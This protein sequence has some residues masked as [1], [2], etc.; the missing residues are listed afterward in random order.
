MNLIERIY[1]E[2]VKATSSQREDERFTLLFQRGCLPEYIMDEDENKAEKAVSIIANVMCKPYQLCNETQ[3]MMLPVLYRYALDNRIPS[4]WNKNRLVHTKNTMTSVKSNPYY[5]LL[6]DAKQSMEQAKK[7]LTDGSVIYPVRLHPKNWKDNLK[8]GFSNIDLLGS[9]EMYMADYIKMMEKRERLIRSV[10][11]YSAETV[12]SETV[13]G[14]KDIL[15]VLPESHYYLGIFR[16]IDKVSENTWEKLFCLLKCGTDEEKLEIRENIIQ[17]E[18]ELCRFESLSHEYFESVQEKK[19]YLKEFKNEIM[20]LQGDIRKQ[21][22]N[23]ELSMYK[24]INEGDSLSGILPHNIDET[25]EEI[26][27]SGT[28]GELLEATTLSFEDKNIMM[29]LNCLFSG[30]V[31]REMDEQLLNGHLQIIIGGLAKRV[32]IEREWFRKEVIQ[33]DKFKSIAEVDFNT[34]PSAFV[35]M[36]DITIKFIFDAVSII[37]VKKFIR[38]IR[39]N[40]SFLCFGEIYQDRTANYDL[41]GYTLMCKYD[42]PVLLGYYQEQVN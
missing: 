9:S 24:D 21:R 15:N 5:E 23:I 2:V 17:F 12:D 8:S 4:D 32:D 13:N 31:P 6:E 33:S 34:Y 10:F 26:I 20:K 7:F 28:Y 30:Y 38:H 36:K 35:I 25:Y 19:E 3:L 18:T 27:V 37:L 16:K 22:I 11:R 1:N 29:S 42:W 41:S 14:I 40:K 39:Q